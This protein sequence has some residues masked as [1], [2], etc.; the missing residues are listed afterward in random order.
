MPPLRP[1]GCLANGTRQ[2]NS[3]Y[4]LVYNGFD[5][6]I[7][8]NMSYRLS[9]VIICLLLSS[10]SLSAQL[11][12][13]NPYYGTTLP[14][15]LKAYYGEFNADGGSNFG[16]NIGWGSG[17]AGGGF[18]QNTFFE[19]QYNFHKGDLVY[20]D[21]YGG[22]PEDL[23]VLK[24][25]NALAGITKATGNEVIEGYGGVYAGVTIFDVE[26][27]EAFDYT[28]FTMAAALGLKYY[29]TPVVGIRLH[30]QLYLPFWAS[31]AYL[32]WSGGTSGTISSLTSPYMNFNIGIFA[33]I[34]RS[35]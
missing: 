34:D 8:Y 10:W 27:P 16:A 22:L 33:N 29:V 32:G 2:R 25:H 24:V 19:L 3:I 12:Q 30:T 11:F 6:L 18:S 21:Y 23:G 28:R 17:I 7:F 20:R 26:D 5:T 31:S 9:L 1:G 15:P 14:M 13:F 4:A 35:Y